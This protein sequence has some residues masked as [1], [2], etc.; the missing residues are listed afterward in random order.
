MKSPA[1]VVVVTQLNDYNVCV[2]LRVWLD[3]ERRHIEARTQ[4]REAV[5]KALT[6]AG[7]DMP[8]E[9]FHIEPLTVRQV[10]A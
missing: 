9:T 2:E 7:V 3:D 4:L 10:A 1:P 5:F 8:F 6:A